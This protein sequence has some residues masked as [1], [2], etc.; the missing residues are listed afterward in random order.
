MS[1]SIVVRDLATD[2]LVT[3]RRSAVWEIRVWISTKVQQQNY[4]KPLS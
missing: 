1:E 3:G 4:G 2:I